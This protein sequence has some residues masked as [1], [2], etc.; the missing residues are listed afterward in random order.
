M[1]SFFA[2]VGVAFAL[3]SILASQ[4]Q[5]QEAVWPSSRTLLGTIRGVVRDAR[6][7]EPVVG[8]NVVIDSRFGAMVLENG[9][10]TITDVPP[11]VHTLQAGTIGYH[12]A[13]IEDIV[14]QPGRET[15][16]PTSTLAVRPPTSGLRIIRHDTRK[17]WI[18]APETFPCTYE[19]LSLPYRPARHARELS[20]DELDLLTHFYNE[21]VLEWIFP[22]SRDHAVTNPLPV[23]ITTWSGLADAPSDAFFAGISS[24]TLRTVGITSANDQPFYCVLKVTQQVSPD[25]LE[26]EASL[27]Q[28]S[29]GIGR[30]ALATRKDG[31]WSFCLSETMFTSIGCGEASPSRSR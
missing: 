10:F 16:L 21:I 19:G 14:V 20:A 26:V 7:N 23:L 2:V 25:T 12:W 8:A 4:S 5:S 17:W 28:R 27:N 3:A 13:T 1:R 22:L 6:T 31:R 29:R 15:T 24:D 18:G 9:A 11:G 30:C